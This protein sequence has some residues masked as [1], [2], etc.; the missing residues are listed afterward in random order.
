MR[1]IAMVQ[2]ALA[3]LVLRSVPCLAHGSRYNVFRGGTGIE[4]THDDGSPM[5]FCDVRVFAPGGRENLHQTGTTGP[6]G[7]F[8][9]VPDTNGV[10]RVSIDDGIGHVL[11]AEIAVGPEAREAVGRGGGVDRLTGGVVGVSL[12]FG[13][14]GIYCLLRHRVPRS[15]RETGCTEG[16]NSCTLPKA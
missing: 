7:R 2:L 11:W 14:F 13:V 8:M 15:Q 9:F 5:A 3:C 4:A 10:W 6:K 16:E 12:I 1:G